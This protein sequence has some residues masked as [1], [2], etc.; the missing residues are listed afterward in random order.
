MSEPLRVLVYR[1]AADGPRDSS[2]LSAYRDLLAEYDIEL[3]T[4]DEFETSGIQVPATYAGRVDDA[5][6]D[7]VATMDLSAV[8]WADVL[9]FGGWYGTTR[10]CDVCD[11]AAPDETSGKQ[12]VEVTGHAMAARDRVVRDL[13]A[14]IENSPA[15]LRGR[16]MVYELD[17]DLFALRPSLRIYRRI[18]VELDLVEHLARRADLVT[19]ATPALAVCMRRRSAAV[20]VIRDAVRLGSYANDGSALE[21][22]PLSFLYYGST[23]GLHDYAICRDAVDEIALATGGRRIWIGCDAAE[24][25]ALVDEVEPNIVGARDFALS[26]AAARPVVGLAPVAQD[27][28]S[29]GRSELA[30]LEYSL[31]GAATVASRTLGEGPYDVIRDGVD[32]LLARDKAQWRH[33]LRAV[34]ESRALREELAGRARERVVAEYDVRKRAGEWADALRWAADHAGLGALRGLTRGLGPAETGARE[35]ALEFEARANLAHRRM[36]RARSVEERETLA[37]LR[38]EREVCWPEGADDNPLVSVII[39]TYNRGRILVERSIASVLA[40]TYQNLEVVVVGDHATDVTIA[41]VRT[42]VDPRV[43]FENLPERSPYPS[44]PELAW[45]CVGSRPYNRGV[46][47]ARGQWIAPQADDDEFTPDHIEMLLSVAIENRLEFVYGDS[48]MEMPDGL[49]IRLGEW[50]PRQAGFCA[51]AVL[52]SS[53]LRFAGLDEECWR[54]GLPNDWDMWDRMMK[55][56]VRAGH[57][58]HIVF[59][60]YREARH[61]NQAIAR[62]A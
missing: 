60:H 31:S 25:R 41:A 20:R 5:I 58:E 42:V 43:R 53:G 49:W 55:A 34:A 21:P 27:A 38:G 22:R 26:L 6:R 54:E 9:V 30:W 23:D 39:P 15:V 35:R 8:E 2:R 51:G 10:A 11:F 45:M 1:S 59:R 57:V 13:V 12:H 18:Q 32:G 37:R 44:D 62:S 61:R 40:Q 47:L 17:D 52:Y 50:P 36:V 29:R 56:G 33:Q 24:V 19:V 14:A 16:A 3:R 28:Y 4:W 46:E 7:G 48:W